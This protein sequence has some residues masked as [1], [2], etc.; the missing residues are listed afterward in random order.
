MPDG[1]DVLMEYSQAKW[2]SIK[3]DLEQLLNSVRPES[4]HSRTTF[5]TDEAD[6]QAAYKPTHASGL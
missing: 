6:A 1:S 2:T 3:E 4:M 5:R